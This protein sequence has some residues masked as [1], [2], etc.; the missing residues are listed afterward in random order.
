[1]YLYRRIDIISVKNRKGIKAASGFSMTKQLK[2]VVGFSRRFVL[3]QE[4]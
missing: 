4:L 2:K 1:M 3:F